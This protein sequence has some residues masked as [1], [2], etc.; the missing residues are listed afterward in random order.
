MRRDPRVYLAQIL[1]CADRIARY[2]RDGEHAFEKLDQLERELAG[3]EPLS[4]EQ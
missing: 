1:E 3:D 4:P 2:I